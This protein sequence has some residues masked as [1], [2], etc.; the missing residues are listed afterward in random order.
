MG[1]NRRSIAT[2][3]LQRIDPG[4]ALSS[5]EVEQWKPGFFAEDR[6]RL[7][8]DRH[9]VL[10]WQRVRVLKTEK[11]KWWEKCRSALRPCIYNLCDGVLECG[12]PDRVLWGG[13][14]KGGL[15]PEDLIQ[16]QGPNYADDAY[17][18]PPQ[19]TAEARR[20]GAAV[21]KLDPEYWIVEW[22]SELDYLHRLV[23]TISQ[24]ALQAGT[25]ILASSCNKLI[26]CL[27]IEEARAAKL[28]GL[29]GDWS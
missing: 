23:P 7:L 15:T 6:I 28:Q 2:L 26:H 19:K 8:C 10:T 12:M 16:P 22:V 13:L 29:L 9:L 1:K 5:D 24:A 11:I 27:N 3:Y 4:L 17:V 21:A 25:D 14:D 20:L 18:L